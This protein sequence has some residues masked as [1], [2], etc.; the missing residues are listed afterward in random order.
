MAGE[1]GSIAED[2]RRKGRR[3]LNNGKD[4]R[5]EILSHERMN[6]DERTSGHF[7]SMLMGDGFGEVKKYMSANHRLISRTATF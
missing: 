3:L 2:W 7:G 6:V 4:P 5:R 1:G